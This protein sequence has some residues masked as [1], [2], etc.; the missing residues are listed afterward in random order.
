MA[1]PTSQGGSATGLEPREYTDESD[2]S[3]TELEYL[4]EVRALSLFTSQEPEDLSFLKDDIL[5]VIDDS[6]KDGWLLAC[7]ENGEQG[8]VPG[9]HVSVEGEGTADQVEGQVL[10]Q[11]GAKL[12]EKVRKSAAPDAFRLALRGLGIALPTG[13]REST[14][15]KFHTFTLSSRFKPKLSI[16]GLSFVDPCGRPTETALEKEMTILYA[17]NVPEVDS[18]LEVVSCQVRLCVYDRKTELASNMLC[19]SAVMPTADKKT[20]KLSKEASN[21]EVILSVKSADSNL[22]LVVELGVSYKKEGTRHELSTGWACLPLFHENGRTT[23]QN[24]TY[25]LTLS[26]GN[27]FEEGV[28]LDPDSNLSNKKSLFST[29]RKPAVLIRFSPIGRNTRELT[30]HLPDDVI[31][32]KAY[33]PLT[34]RYQKIAS[35]ILE[36]SSLSITAPEIHVFLTA[37]DRPLVM[38]TVVQV[39]NDINQNKRRTQRLNDAI[40]N[41]CFIDFVLQKIYPLLV[42]P[43]LE[44]Q[45][46]KQSLIELLSGENESDSPLLAYSYQFT[47][48]NVSETLTHFI[49]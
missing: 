40:Q 14:L 25:V 31:I 23:L 6:R 41:Q 24:K 16:T 2:L 27:L 3:E 35:H 10:K 45:L 42:S 33:L 8:L 36:S 26:G 9:N 13:F 47:P 38:D 28:E 44:D 11:S 21:R 48:F 12:W 20:W 39:W 29:N 17:S 18:Q 32:P 30:T 22:D 46:S 7:N 19:L 37:L 49:T 5:Y 4:Y 1:T 15:A 34:Y 43:Q